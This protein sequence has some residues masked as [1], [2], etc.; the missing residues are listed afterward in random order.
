[1][2]IK[3]LIIANS[4][5]ILFLIFNQNDSLKD[6]TKQTSSSANSLEFPT[7]FCFFFELILL[8]L[9]TKLTDF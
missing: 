7:W 5:L 6:V 8:L 4:F 3:S 9:Q 2:F 1:M